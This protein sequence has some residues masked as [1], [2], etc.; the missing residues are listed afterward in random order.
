[1]ILL[2]IQTILLILIFCFFLFTTP[3]FTYCVS[4]V[5]GLVTLFYFRKMKR[6]EV[7][8]INIISS[9][10][11]AIIFF[12]GYF[13]LLSQFKQVILSDT[14]FSW[15]YIAKLLMFINVKDSLIKVPVSLLI[16]NIPSV[17]YYFFGKSK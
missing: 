13:L 5:L 11:V 14:N 4:L 3:I 12:L 9:I 16:F 8:K 2:I 17:L 7:I 10:I 6:I 15:E 1:M